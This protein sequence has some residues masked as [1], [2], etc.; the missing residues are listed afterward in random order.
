MYMCAVC[1]VL[2]VVTKKRRA[3]NFCHSHQKQF[4]RFIRSIHSRSTFVR[5]SPY[6]RISMKMFHIF[7]F[8][9][10][11]GARFDFIFFRLFSLLLF[12]SFVFKNWFIF[13]SVG[14]FF[15][16]VGWGWCEWMV[17]RFHF[18]E[19]LVVSSCRVCLG[20]IFRRV[21]NTYIL[22]YGFYRS[23]AWASTTDVVCTVK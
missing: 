20:D 22:R 11:V 19:I 23:W 6:I 13:M 5:F 18:C 15:S 3:E 10:L 8:F 9:F 4:F 1:S 2:C 21:S 14:L 16:V 17:F 7:F 12:P